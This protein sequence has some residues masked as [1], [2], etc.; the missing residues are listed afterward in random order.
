MAILTAKHQSWPIAGRFTISRGTK[1]SCETII[2]EITKG[3]I[4]GRGECVPYARYGENIE[5]TLAEIMSFAKNIADG[6]TKDDLQ[7]IM[8]AGAARNAI[9][10]AMWDLEAKL[11]GRPV[12]QLANL[13]LPKP[14]IT[15]YTISLGS[16]DA[17]ARQ[18]LENNHRPLM[19]LKLTGNGDMER[20]SA[21]HNA[22]PDC[23][24]IVDANEAWSDEQVVPFSK[25][26]KQLG[27][28]MIEQPLP[29]D[30]DDILANFDHPIAL[31]A[32]ESAHGCADFNKLIGKYEMINIK[33]DKTGGLTEALKLRDMAI[34]NNMQ[35]MVGCMLASSLSMAPA[36]LIAENAHMV[37]L[38]GP[39]LLAKDCQNPIEFDGS[40]MMPASRQ[41][42]G[43]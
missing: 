19:K 36:M 22:V 34:A 17:M 43:N 10:C 23:R 26:L 37:D 21:V 38:D 30:K 11:T 7:N 39:L 24:L 14:I 20:V 8:K 6:A 27:V 31:C 5:N 13:K 16:P 35:V 1:T 2:A 4:K 12:W 33:I 41:L 18:A 29:A 28:E 42:W 40:L 15:A 32:D 25:Q 9:D 3:D